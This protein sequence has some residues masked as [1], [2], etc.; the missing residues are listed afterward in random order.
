MV[1]SAA[2]L[3]SIERSICTMSAL[4]LLVIG[5]YR[6]AQVCRPA[7]DP[8]PRCR[9]RRACACNPGL[10]MSAT[11]TAVSAVSGACSNA[12][13]RSRDAPSACAGGPI[14]S[15]ASVRT[16]SIPPSGEN[17]AQALRIT[18]TVTTNARDASRCFM[19]N[20]KLEEPSKRGRQHASR[21]NDGE[22]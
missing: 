15:R 3:T 11:S 19:A 5:E 14:R 20:P 21:R 8:L 4:R 6:V 18:A 12:S 2:T 17:D 13:T 22:R 1:I 9:D 7:P 10:L 16:S